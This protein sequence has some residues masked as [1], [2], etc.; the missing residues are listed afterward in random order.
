MKPTRNI[1]NMVVN[2]EN[3]GTI[4]RS[5]VPDPDYNPDPDNFA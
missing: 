5:W 3:P 1:G 2:R 4:Y